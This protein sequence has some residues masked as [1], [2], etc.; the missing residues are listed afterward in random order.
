[1][2]GRLSIV[3]GSKGSPAR[4]TDEAQVTLRNPSFLAASSTL[5]VDITFTWNMTE[6]TCRRMTR[7][8]VHGRTE[9]GER[10]EG[11][12]L[13]RAVRRVKRGGAVSLHEEDELPA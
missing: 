6:F 12:L 2:T 9:A 13:G 4:V 3:L 5:Y 7:S 10:E 11:V 1:M 8:A